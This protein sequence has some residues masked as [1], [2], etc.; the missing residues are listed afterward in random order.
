LSLARLWKHQGKTGDARK[1]LS[2]TLAWFTEGF[3]TVD[4]R[5]AK[6]FLNELGESTET[7]IN[8]IRA[9]E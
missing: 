3:E 5:D 6:A 4:L 2:D 1:L 7:G 9:A 8:D